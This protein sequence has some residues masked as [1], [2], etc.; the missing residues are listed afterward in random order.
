M[1]QRK[2]GG[3]D[4]AAAR[5]LDTSSTDPGAASAE[6]PG[7]TS[8]VAPVGLDYSDNTLT[9][10]PDRS[11]LTDPE[12]S[13]PLYIDPVWQSSTNSAWA[14]V[15]SGYPNEE[16]W[17]FDGKRH[18][19]IGLCPSS[20]NN[21]KVKRLFYRLATPYSGKTILEATFRVTL[22]HVYNS[23]ARA[24]ALYLMPAGI[25]SSTNWSNQPG[26]SGWSE[27]RTSPPAHRPRRRPPVPPPTR[28]R[29]G[30]RRPRCS[31]R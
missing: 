13:F 12:A 18:E 10:T 1:G 22:Q 28:T 9:L 23:T 3:G 14:M 25:T 21:S 7:D 24:A 15:D 5:S 29:S 17:K 6:G 20:C 19:R 2:P 16:Y 11:M 27:R 30:T 26:G 31:R 4:A 8:E